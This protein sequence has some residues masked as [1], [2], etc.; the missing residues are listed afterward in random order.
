MKETKYFEMNSLEDLRNFTKKFVARLQLP[1]LLFLEGELG[2]GK[3][4]FVRSL[5]DFALAK[6]PVASPTFSLHH[7][8]V[9]PEFSVHHFDFYRLKD[10]AEIESTGIYE[11][12]RRPNG[13]VVVEWPELMKLDATPKGWNFCR[14]KTIVEGSKRIIE[15]SYEP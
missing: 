6:G 5:A 4:Q 14:L 2:A 15:Q 8:Y 12:L 11:C 13:L 7:E 3:T 10:E 9:T 1:Q